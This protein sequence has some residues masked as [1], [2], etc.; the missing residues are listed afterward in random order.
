[1]SSVMKLQVSTTDGNT[2]E[3]SAIM[4]DLIKFDVLRARLSLPGREE[5]EF[6][7]MGIVAYAA[8][9]RTGAVDRNAKPMEFLETIESIEPVE[10]PAEGAEFPATTGD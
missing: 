1:M 9:T 2:F 8:L 7:F 3:V 10:D 6:V 4:A 5:G